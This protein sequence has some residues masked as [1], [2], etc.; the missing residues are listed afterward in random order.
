VAAVAE[1]MVLMAMMEMTA[2]QEETAPF[3]VQMQVVLQ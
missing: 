1:A 2:L 3:Q